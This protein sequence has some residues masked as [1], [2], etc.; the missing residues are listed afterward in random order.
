MEILRAR[1]ENTSMKSKSCLISRAA[2]YKYRQAWISLTVLYCL[3][4]RLYWFV[5]KTSVD[6][7]YLQ[8]SANKAMSTFR[9]L[10]L[11]KAAAAIPGELL[12]MY[13]LFI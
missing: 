7:H 9:Q 3:K 4:T 6:I 2:K 1:C 5:L 13:M 8:F 11:E 12:F 10:I